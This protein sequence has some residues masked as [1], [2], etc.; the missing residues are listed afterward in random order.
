MRSDS[1]RSGVTGASKSSPPATWAERSA[2]FG[3]WAVGSGGAAGVALVG[4]TGGPDELRQSVLAVTVFGFF[5]LGVTRMALLAWTQPIRRGPAM[6]LGVGVLLWGSGS[7]IL[8]A[9]DPKL[10]PFPAPFP[11]PYEAFFLLSYV[12]VVASLLIDV[13][14]AGRSATVWLETAVLCGGAASMTGFGLLAAPFVVP[15]DQQLALLFA[16]FYSILDLLLVGLIVVQ[17]RRGQRVWGRSS[18]LMIAGFGGLAAADSELFV[19]IAA[20]TFTGNY[21]GSLVSAAA[22]AA[23]W[24]LVITGACASR[25]QPA[26]AFARP[27]APRTLLGAAA[28]P[29][30]IL[31]VRPA[32]DLQWYLAVPALLTVL[33]VGGR[34]SVAIRTTQRALDLAH[35]DELTGLPNRRA[36]T[37][38]TATA[39]ATG[40]RVAVLLID[41][42]GFK[43]INDT[44]GHRAGD[45]VLQEVAARAARQVHDPD[46]VARLGGDE[47]AALLLA[48]D[49]PREIMA[50]A[51][52]LRAVAL[53]PIDITRPEGREA[54]AVGASIGVSLSVPTDQTAGDLLHRADAAMYEAKGTPSGV[55][56]RLADPEPPGSPGDDRP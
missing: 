1:A 2:L 43:A 46:M 30:A 23:G 38:T 4:A 53:L 28:V 9:G 16:A 8:N 15:T 32:G 20:G 25:R 26:L 13:R 50:R 51:R 39:L 48:A 24:A 10:Q 5:V 7:A 31:F 33:A 12:A 3:M 56:A 47:F 6:L 17:V 21:T 52:E 14:P 37:A 22:Y 35:T 29:L 34:W 44:F 45:Q 18:L 27:L 55:A 54:P 49:D 42:D 36:F 40:Q 11:A 19:R 41:L